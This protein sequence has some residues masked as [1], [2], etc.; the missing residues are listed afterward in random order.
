[1]RSI[2]KTSAL[3]RRAVLAGVGGLLLSAAIP[4]FAFGLT[5]DTAVSF[6]NTVMVDVH[7]IINSGKSE[8][9]MLVDFEAI[10]R[11]HGEV[12]LIAKTA[13]GAPGRAASSAQISAYIKAFQGYISRKYG[14]QF[15]DFAGAEMAVVSSRNL[16]AKGVLVKSKVDRPVEP[17]F[18][19]D[20]WVIEINGRPK[21]FDLIIEGISLIS[22]ERTEIGAMLESF[23]GDIDKMTAKLLV[24]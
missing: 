4:T 6:I 14:R 16:S 7:A 3:P 18:D 20:W 11:D 22:T 13:L 8:T 2:T 23:G 15:R 17:N 12:P 21:L 24:T 9:R 10:F 5:E 19:L 1:M